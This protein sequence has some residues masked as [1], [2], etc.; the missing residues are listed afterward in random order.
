MIV[1][2]LVS[3]HYLADHHQTGFGHMVKLSLS[4]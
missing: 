1:V 2:N 3:Q 4:I